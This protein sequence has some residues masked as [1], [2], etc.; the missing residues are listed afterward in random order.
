MPKYNKLFASKN[1]EDVRALDI[2]RFDRILFNSF[3]MC[4]GSP[5]HPPFNT[6]KKQYMFLYSGYAIRVW[7]YA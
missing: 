7:T 4:S 6:A 3:F 5:Q 2:H 1:F